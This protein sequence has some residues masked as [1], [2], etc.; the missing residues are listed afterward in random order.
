MRT[1]AAIILLC[2]ACGAD[3]DAASDG[4]ADARAHDGG[5][6]DATNDAPIADGSARDAAEVDAAEVD[7]VVPDAHVTPAGSVVTT[8]GAACDGVTDDTAAIQSAFDDAGS[9]TDDTLVFPRGA[10]C[11]VSSTVTLGSSGWTIEG[12][13]ATL[14]AADG[15]PCNTGSGIVQLVSATDFTVHDLDT[16]G[17]R[18][19]RTPGE[20]FG[21]HSWNIRGAQNGT[22]RDVDWYDGCTDDVRIA[23]TDA[24]DTDQY[25][26]SLVFSDSTFENAY[27]NDVS[28]IEGWDIRFEGT[29]SG[30]LDGTCTC[31]MTNA[32]GTSPECGIDWE[33]NSGSAPPGVQNGVV[34]G[35]LF[36]GNAQCAWAATNIAG[37]RDLD[38]R[39]SIVR[40]NGSETSEVVS[41]NALGLHGRGLIVENNWIG[42]QAGAR[43]GV[44]YVAGAGASAT[45]TTEIRNNFIDGTPPIGAT[46]GSRHVIWFGNFGDG[47]AQFHDNTLTRIGVPASGDWCNPGPSGGATT[48]RDN[49]VDGTLQSPNP[50]CP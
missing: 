12:E 32:H 7:A 44:I 31:R 3:D 2:A 49:T 48:T 27:R 14:T 15:M 13:G 50:G 30:G 18:D 21:G 6:T 43:F 35:C 40:N 45:R 29:C 28:V 26:K 11:I 33:P 41:N 25:S 19:G 42:Q 5:A 20:F 46:S 17:N 37:T 36:E 4:G 47:T 39:S 10:V 24:T 34:D 1:L 22:F 16:D 38:L 23:S 8:Y 9:W